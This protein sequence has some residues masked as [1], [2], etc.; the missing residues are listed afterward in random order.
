MQVGCVRMLHVK[1]GEMQRAC[2]VMR[3]AGQGNRCGA[4]R[5]VQVR[6]CE[7]TEQNAKHYVTRGSQVIPQPSTGR[8][9]RFLTSLC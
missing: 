1:H 2:M 3:S 8:A 6:K 9:Q 4:S 7:V 5:S